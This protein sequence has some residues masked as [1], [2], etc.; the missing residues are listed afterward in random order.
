[1]GSTGRI[2]NELAFFIDVAQAAGNADRRKPVLRW[3]RQLRLRMSTLR[4]FGP[5]QW[6]NGL[7]NFVKWKDF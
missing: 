5:M 2:P 7:A 1:M 4:L 3:T 6:S